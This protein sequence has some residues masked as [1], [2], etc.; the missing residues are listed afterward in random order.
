M[1]KYYN[2]QNGANFLATHFTTIEVVCVRACVY[3]WGVGE[4][5]NGKLR[6]AEEKQQ[7][8]SENSTHFTNNSLKL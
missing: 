3:V 4:D 1:H 7:A 6:W 5:F 8:G 2:E